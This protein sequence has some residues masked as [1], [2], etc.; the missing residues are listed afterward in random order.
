MCGWLWNDCQVKLQ[1]PNMRGTLITL[2]GTIA[3]YTVTGLK[4]SAQHALYTV[5]VFRLWEMSTL[6][7]SMQELDWGEVFPALN[8]PCMQ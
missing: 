8:D 2:L 6:L 4:L 3:S 5:V 7:A 1:L